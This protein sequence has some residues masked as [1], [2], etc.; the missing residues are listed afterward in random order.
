MLTTQD[1]YTNQHLVERGFVHE[2]NHPVHGKI[3]LLGWPVKMSESNVPLIPAPQLGE[4]TSEVLSAELGLTDE[5][6]ERLVQSSV[7]GA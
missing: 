2:V 4:H 6:V 1:L 5:E 7:V 3:K